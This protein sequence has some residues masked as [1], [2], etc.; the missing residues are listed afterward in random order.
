[1]KVSLKLVVVALVVCA[2]VTESFAQR[3]RNSD[4]SGQSGRRRGI[5]GRQQGRR[6]NSNRGGSSSAAVEESLPPQPPRES[7]RRRSGNVLPVPDVGE[8]APQ[9]GRGR[10]RNGR[11]RQEGSNFLRG[12]VQG[13]NQGLRRFR[14][15]QGTMAETL[16]GVLTQTFDNI[17]FEAISDTAFRAAE[18][19]TDVAS[20]RV[21]R[22]MFVALLTTTAGGPEDTLAVLRGDAELA[23]PI[24]NQI[25]ENYRN[26]VSMAAEEAGTFLDVV[27]GPGRVAPSTDVMPTETSEENLV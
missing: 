15:W 25:A 1:M 8:E 22:S 9:E 18:Y 20:R 6:R 4:G 7:G 23:Q 16:N 26:V 3:G 2:C 24:L 19:F 12:A 10:R 14:E 21:P 17:P 11:E 13:L 5:R 27:L